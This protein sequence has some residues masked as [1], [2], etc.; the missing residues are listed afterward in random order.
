[1]KPAEI[2]VFQWISAGFDLAAGEGFEPSQT[3]SESGV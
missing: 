1:M 3:E 2:L